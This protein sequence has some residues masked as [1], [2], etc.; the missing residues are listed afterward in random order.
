M[1]KCESAHRLHHVQFS[2]FVEVETEP[3]Q[4]VMSLA[5]AIGGESFL[6]WMGCEDLNGIAMK[7]CAPRVSLRA[8][9]LTGSL[10]FGSMLP[11][12]VC[13]EN[14]FFYFSTQVQ[15]RK[16]CRE[17]KHRPAAVHSNASPYLP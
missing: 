3:D 4:T 10:G 2:A 8:P 11:R 6:S 7:T 15:T 12:A 9:S 14:D 16:S 5:F 13:V 17:L 1:A